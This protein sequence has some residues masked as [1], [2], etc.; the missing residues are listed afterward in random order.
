MRRFAQTT[1]W[2]CARDRFRCRI[3]RHS[4]R[5]RSY[6]S[7]R[8]YQPGPKPS[9]S[10][11]PGTLAAAALTE[12]SA[13]GSSPLQR[14]PFDGML[15]PTLRTRP[16]SAGNPAGTT[17]PGG[18]AS[19][20]GRRSWRGWRSLTRRLGVVVR[21]TSTSGLA[22]GSNCSRKAGRMATMPRRWMMCENVAGCGVK[23]S[24]SS[25][26]PG[27]EGW[28]VRGVGRTMVP[29]P[30]MIGRRGVACALRWP[31]CCV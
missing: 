13:S 6:Q 5:C 23:V 25:G 26:R 9:V 1:D 4:S 20:R 2:Q 16:D 3:R 14:G 8:C 21:G 12:A 10:G 30:S 7:T 31:W 11:R 19:A 18:A 15:S 28:S 27:K 29:Y 24:V 17:G 22:G